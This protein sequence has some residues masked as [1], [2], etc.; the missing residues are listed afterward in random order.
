MLVWQVDIHKTS[1]SNGTSG[2]YVPVKID[3]VFK[4]LPNIFG[5]VNDILIVG[6]DADGRD[7]N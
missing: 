5:I 7:H 4:G 6:Y 1:I 3:V 2:W